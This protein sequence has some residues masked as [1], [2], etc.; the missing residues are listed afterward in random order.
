MSEKG[1]R[2]EIPVHIKRDRRARKMIAEGEA[3]TVQ[4]AVPRIARLLALGHKW[5]GMVR[6]GEVKNYAEIA[7]RMGLSR[8]RVTQI[9]YLALLAPDI[10]EKIL[11]ASHDL[12]PERVL[13]CVVVHVLWIDSRDG[14][15]AGLIDRVQISHSTS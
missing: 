2:I 5:E 14:E 8:A 10:Q 3:P 1:F 13:R 12:L 11:N 4:A 15:Q 9:G 7:T 6:R